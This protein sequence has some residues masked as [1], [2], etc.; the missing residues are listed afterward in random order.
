MI[1]STKIAKQGQDCP[2]GQWYPIGIILI[3][4]SNMFTRMLLMLFLEP[5]KSEASDIVNGA[6]R[7]SFLQ[8]WPGVRMWCT[9]AH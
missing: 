2:V 4:I 8:S 1:F 3:L 6:H 7:G 9:E 5:F